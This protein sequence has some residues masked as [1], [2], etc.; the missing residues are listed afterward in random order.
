MLLMNEGRYGE[1]Q[2][3]LTKALVVYSGTDKLESRGLK[4]ALA[5]TL[6]ELGQYTQANGYLQEVIDERPEE[7]RD[8]I[9]KQAE[10]CLK[11][12]DPDMR[13]MYLMKVVETAVPFEQA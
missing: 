1:A 12:G 13:A 10:N 6:R 4:L 11:D 2:E 8:L 3:Y 5:D 7:C 9:F